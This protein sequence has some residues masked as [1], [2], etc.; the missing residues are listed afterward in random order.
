MLTTREISKSN[1]IIIFQLILLI[2]TSILWAV[3]GSGT[4]EEFFIKD[5][6]VILKPN[7]SNEIISAQ[8]YWRGGVLNLTKTN[9]GIEQFI[10]SSATLKNRK[11]ADKSWDKILQ[12]TGS[13]LGS[14]AE[15]NFTVISLQCTRQYFDQMWEVFSDYVMNSGFYDER[16]EIARER[17]LTR[18]RRQ[19]DTPDVYVRKLAEEQFYRDHPYELEPLGVQESISKINMKQ[20]ESY[21]KKNLKKSKLLLVVVGNVDKEKLKKKVAKTFGKISKGKYKPVFPA[22][23][24]HKSPSLKIVER[25]LPTNY[26]LGLFSAPSPENPDYYPMTIAIDFLKWRLFEEIRTKRSLSYAPDAFLATNFANYGG[27]YA[28][29]VEPDTTIKIM[30]E[31][32][33]KL[34]MEPVIEKDLRDRISMNL[35]R[36]YLSNES[37]SAQGQFLA[38]FELSGLGWQQGE[39]M[40]ENL[41][42]VTAAD[43]QRVANQYF[44]NIQFIVLGNPKLIDENLITLL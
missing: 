16:T 32:L 30:L 13:R 39:K 3:N 21:L 40:V 15:K 24:V 36:Y 28:T 19:K 41:R 23:V 9:Q 31:E 1:L 10:F 2:L 44:K 43:V 12:G 35:T 29:S 34:R 27:V 26:I 22:V 4:T 11:Y 17:T 5:L 18:I 20:M 25:D 8:L 14:A 7:T 42:N 38:R 37:N 6:K 33:K